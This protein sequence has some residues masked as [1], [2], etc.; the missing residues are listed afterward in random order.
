MSNNETLLELIR[1]YPNLNGNELSG[2]TPFHANPLLMKLEDEGK[3]IWTG[4]GWVITQRFN[5][6]DILEENMK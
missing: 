2:M 1:D 4:R 3:I 6:F 5:P